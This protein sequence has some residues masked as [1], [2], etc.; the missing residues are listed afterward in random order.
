MVTILT[1]SI[2]ELVAEISIGNCFLPSNPVTERG[3]N[4]R[5]AG[6]FKTSS[7]MEFREASIFMHTLMLL[8]IGKT[9]RTTVYISLSFFL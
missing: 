8:P 6:Y 9:L 1:I 4:R 2:F 3:R 5:D 7:G